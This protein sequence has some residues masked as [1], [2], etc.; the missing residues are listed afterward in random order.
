[1]QYMVYRVYSDVSG[2]SGS[3]SV[4]LS[5]ACMDASD[6]RCVLIVSQPTQAERP[7]CIQ[8]T[9]GSLYNRDQPVKSVAFDI[10]PTNQGL[11][12]PMLTNQPA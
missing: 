11:G 3:C 1:M 9:I 7:I 8:E 10:D 4:C 2:I 5:I 12:N 6:S